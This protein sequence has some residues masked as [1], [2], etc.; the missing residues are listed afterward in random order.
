MLEEEFAERIIGATIEVHRDW[1]PCL[2]EE[3]NERSFDVL[4]FLCAV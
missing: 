1:G 4:D 2:N 3:I